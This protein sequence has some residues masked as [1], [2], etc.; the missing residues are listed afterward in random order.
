[1]FRWRHPKLAVE[2]KHLAGSKTRHATVKS[3]RNRAWASALS[4]GRKKYGSQEKGLQSGGPLPLRKQ[5]RGLGDNSG[6]RYEKP[7]PLDRLLK[8]FGKRGVGFQSDG[9]WDL[10]APGLAQDRLEPREH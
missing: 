10:A 9:P 7:A 5:I 2:V 1:M 8:G 3:Y 6:T 4:E